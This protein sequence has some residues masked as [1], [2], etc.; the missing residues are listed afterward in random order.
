MMPPAPPE[1]CPSSMTSRTFAFAPL[2][3]WCSTLLTSAARRHRGVLED[4]DHEVEALVDDRVLGGRDL[5]LVGQDDVLEAVAGHLLGLE[6]G[7]RP[8]A[9]RRRR[10]PVVAGADVGALELVPDDAAGVA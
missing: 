10:H 1:N 3:Q 8:Q 2:R 5:A 6:H 4:L 9:G 7:E